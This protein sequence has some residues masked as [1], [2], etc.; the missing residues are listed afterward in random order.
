MSLAA[1]QALD[2]S[3]CP[4]LFAVALVTTL[5]HFLHLSFH[6]SAYAALLLLWGFWRWWRGQLPPS[7]WLI[8]L[9]TAITAG[10]IVLDFRSLFGR[11]AGTALLVLFT[12]LKLLELRSRRDAYVSIMLGYFVLLTHFFDSESIPAGL[13]LLT[14]IV[15]VTAALIRLHAGPCCR[16]SLILR[17]AA[18]MTMQALP[19]ML[20]LY[21]LFPRISGPLWGMPKDAYQARTGLNETMTPGNVAE[22]AQSAEIAFRAQ[23]EGK[24]PERSQLYWRGPVMEYTDGST[25]RTLNTLPGVPDIEPLGPAVRYR[26]TLEAHQ[27]RWLL[28]LDAPTALPPDVRLAP[29]LTL[30]TRNPVLQRQRYELAATPLYRFNRQESPLVLR[31][32]LMLPP[33]RNPRTRAL[34]EI[35]RKASPGPERIAELALN[36]FRQE[37]FSYTLRPP[38]LGTE[39]MD[40]FLFSSRRG[41][42]EHY[43]AAFVTLMRAAGVPARVVGGYQGGEINPVD[44]YLVVRQ[45]DAHAWAEVWFAGKGWVRFDPTTV[46]APARI[47]SGIQ[48]AMAGGETLPALVQL[49]APWLKSLR[50]RWEAINNGWNQ[51]VLGYNTERQRALLQHLGI[52]HPH[53]QTLAGLLFGAGG[54]VLLVTTGWVLYHR[55]RLDPSRKL[56]NRALAHLRRRGITCT[57]WEAPLALVSRLRHESPEMGKAMA[58]VARLYVAARYG[59]GPINLKALRQAVSDLP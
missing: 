49:N 39:P 34:A 37:P 31:R 33:N 52:D 50:Y 16:P 25:W 22:L 2:R 45:S 38:L 5:P 51:W 36:Y 3:T 35:W 27:Q 41:F 32:N 19:L 8:V 47:D 56:W 13:W 4:W 42:C 11:E 59:R 18:L 26:L 15:V 7:R 58:E 6:L 54:T 43:A 9:I 17:R 40:D 12:A 24:P 14:S 20:V 23:F 1:P 28:A 53:W 10:L 21:L 48:T 30:L 57:D 46:V 55:P 29:S 44:Q